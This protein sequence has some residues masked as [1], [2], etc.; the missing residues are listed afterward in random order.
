M[1]RDLTDCKICKKSFTD[2]KKI[3]I[4]GRCESVFCATCT[5]LTPS[6]IA[7]LK[8]PAL[9]ALWFCAECKSPAWKSVKSDK[10]IEEKCKEYCKK[11][12]QRMDE[13]EKKLDRKAD[14]SQLGKV[15][16]SVDDLKESLKTKLDKTEFDSLRKEMEELRFKQED[17]L[18][19]VQTTVETEVREWR[20]IDK[21]KSNLMI[22]GMQEQD[23]E[24]TENDMKKIDSFFSGQLGLPK[25]KI[26]KVI[27]IGKKSQVSQEQEE[28]Q[29]AAAQITKNTKKVRPL[30]VILANESDKRKIMKNYWSK[31]DLNASLDYGISSDFTKFE[32]EKY[33]AL[34]AELKK[35][36][37]RG[38]TSW[39]IRKLQLVKKRN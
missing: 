22:Y 23:T 8:D 3:I 32:S 10:E 16:K 14:T 39:C 27:R 5:E 9:G 11:M 15:A 21:R 17:L 28:E 29:G 37:D 18:A 13:L 26:L 35:R 34:K 19:N 25:I 12:E 24:N 4:C 7:V 20:E 33:R 36:E 30:K 31:K 38:D 1:S 6:K 2:N